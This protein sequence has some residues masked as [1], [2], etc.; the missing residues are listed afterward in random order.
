VPAELA[1]A[2][3]LVAAAE[4]AR[5]DL[6]AQADAEHSAVLPLEVAQ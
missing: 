1:G 4:G 3:D 6:A 5:D 2:A